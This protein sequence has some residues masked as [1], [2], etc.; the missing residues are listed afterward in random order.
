MRNKRI[1]DTLKLLIPAKCAAAIL[2]KAPSTVHYFKEKGYF[3]SYK[4]EGMQEDMFELK[5][6]LAYKKKRKL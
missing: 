2:N 6:I 3:C 5:A 4:V 1:D